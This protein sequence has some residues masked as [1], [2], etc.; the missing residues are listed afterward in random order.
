MITSFL[1]ESVK[2]SERI[3][4]PNGLR[5]LEPLKSLAKFQHKF[6]K[7]DHTAA[8]AMS[9]FT[10]IHFGNDFSESEVEYNGQRCAVKG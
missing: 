3:I 4:Y 2:E 10:F 8:P 5:R 9:K 6:V 1:S 7:F